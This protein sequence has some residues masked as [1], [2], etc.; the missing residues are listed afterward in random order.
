MTE[1]WSRLHPNATG[2]KPPLLC[3]PYPMLCRRTPQ[4][5]LIADVLATKL[6]TAAEYGDLD[7]CKRLLTQGVN[8]AS[9]RAGGVGAVHIAASRGHV[10]LLKWLSL[11]GI[12]LD[13]ATNCGAQPIHLAAINGQLEVMK[14]LH[15][16]VEVSLESRTETGAQP[17]HYA[18]RQNTHTAASFEVLMWLRHSGLSTN[19][20]TDDGLTVLEMCNAEVRPWLETTRDFC[21]PL[22]YVVGDRD[23]VHASRPAC[24]F[25][26]SVD[27]SCPSALSSIPRAKATWL[28][29]RAGAT[30]DARCAQVAITARSGAQSRV[31]LRRCLTSI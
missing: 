11:R 16:Q 4:F 27:A 24:V 17:I 23:G 21:T 6:F 31:A 3:L 8:L 12:P 28:L 19:A 20:F 15:K 30:L 14:W 2:T 26:V 13:M 25:S 18:A 5:S 22:H 7:M 29:L 1:D 10:H 9:Q